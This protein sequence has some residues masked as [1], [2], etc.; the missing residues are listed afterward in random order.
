MLPE[1][2]SGPAPGELAVEDVARRLGLP[3]GMLIRRIDAGD[4]P[5]RRVWTGDHHAYYLRLVDLGL[6]E[7]EE[8]VTASIETVGRAATAEPVTSIPSSDPAVSLVG[9]ASEPHA[10]LAAMSIDP[11]ELVAG[12]LDRWERTLEQRIHA[13]QR[14]R[15]E[16][17][18]DA[19]QAQVRQLEAEL[20]TAR[21]EHATTQAQ[22]EREAA[23]MKAQLLE[24]EREL[25]EARAASRRRS[26]FRIR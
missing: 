15:F 23:E 24:R 14:Q 18:L 19:R 17:E 16:A 9:Y 22:R 13:E 2:L 8:P 1:T 21:A 20:Q 6:E 4:V 11:R 3:V 25:A 5:A 26:W 12:L 7:E 10:E